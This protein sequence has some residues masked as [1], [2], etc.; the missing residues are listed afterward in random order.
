M[1]IPSAAFT[2]RGSAIQSG[3][4][5]RAPSSL[6]A[7]QPARSTSHRASARSGVVSLHPLSESNREAVEVCAYR[8]TKSNSSAASP[9]GWRSRRNPDARALYSAVYVEDTRI[10]F[11]MIADEVRSPE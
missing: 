9:I 10:G 7:C 4:G 2:A 11:V 6:R 1:L 8:R 5:P 3:P